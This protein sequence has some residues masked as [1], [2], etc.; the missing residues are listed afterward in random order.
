MG[1]HIVGIILDPYQQPHLV[2][3]F[4]NGSS[5]LITVHAAEFAAVFIDGGIIVQYIDF[6]QMMALAHL[7]VIGVMG[8]RDFHNTGTKFHVHISVRNHGDLSVDN[9]QHQLFANDIFISFILRINCNCCVPQHSLRPC[10]C[11]L[12]EPL[13]TYAP[14]F[15]N[16][17]IFDVPEMA[18]LFLI[19][20][21][22]I[23]NGSIAHGAPVNDAASFIDPSFFMHLA[24]DFRNC[25][26]TSLVHGKT[27]SVPVAGRTQLLKL[28]D[29]AP[30]V[31]FLHALKTLHVQA[32][33]Y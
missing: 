3:F 23:G 33:L 18:C 17:R 7:K 25:P 28:A 19:I 4:Y 20:Y 16:D 11:K 24:E 14:V 6:R 2:Q 8:R 15:L 31:L 29:D 13:R 27:L 22:R 26:V 21:F 12:H 1:S 30:A 32:L 9:G 10:G 5:R